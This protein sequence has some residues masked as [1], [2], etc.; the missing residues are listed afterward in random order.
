MTKAILTVVLIV[1][2]IVA[3]AVFKNRSA[4]APENGLITESPVVCIQDAKQCP[5][6][7]YVSRQ[8]PNCE[9]A[10]CPGTTPS[11]SSGQ[12]SS[13]QA[14]PT[15]TP[16]PTPTSTV[17]NQTVTITFADGTASPK[18]VTIKVG[19]SVKFINNDDVLRWPASGVH[20]THQICPGFD[21]LRGLNKGETYSFTFREAK[22]CPWHDH[23]KTS[24]NGKI[25]VNQ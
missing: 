13:P 4:V 16:T 25:T 9:F 14:S 21:S 2:V 18:D 10:P 1:G 7:S 23:P 22:V 20:P 12:V 24:I 17:K 11:A 19:D 6:G 5:D 3:V 8:G 15:P